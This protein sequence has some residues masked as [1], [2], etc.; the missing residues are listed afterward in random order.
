M[1]GMRLCNLAVKGFSLYLSA[2]VSNIQTPASQAHNKKKKMKKENPTWVRLSEVRHAKRHPP[3]AGKHAT[4]VIGPT[5]HPCFG[6]W[7]MAAL[8]KS[9]VT[10]APHRR[11][12]KWWFRL[13]SGLDTMASSTWQ[14]KQ[15][16]GAYAP[17]QCSKRATWGVRTKGW[18]Q[19][20]MCVGAEKIWEAKLH[21][22]ALPACTATYQLIRD[23]RHEVSP[24]CRCLAQLGR[25]RIICTDHSGSGFNTTRIQRVPHGKGTLGHVFGIGVGFPLGHLGGAKAKRALHLGEVPKLHDFRNHPTACA[26]HHIQC[27]AQATTGAVAHQHTR[28]DDEAHAAVAWHGDTHTRTPRDTSA[29]PAS[30]R[31]VLVTT[32]KERTNATPD[33]R[34]RTRTSTSTNT[35]TM[36]KPCTRCLVLREAHPPL[37]G[38]A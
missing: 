3:G 7:K 32:L 38:L 17:G 1:S 6:G 18:A 36:L 21:N 24:L 26:A 30:R 37:H 5:A 16:Q 11:L 10:R 20:R 4:Q 35:N 13:R 22:D 31:S 19:R 25:R 33:T 34:T 29:W 28:R 27:Q 9:I 23:V 14:R 12:T 2:L 8:A 15:K